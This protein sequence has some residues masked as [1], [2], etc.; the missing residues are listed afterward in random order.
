MEVITTPAYSPWSNGIVERHNQ[1]LTLTLNKIKQEENCNWGLALSWALSAKNALCNIHGF[2]AY[3]LVYGRNPNLPSN[4]T[5]NPPALEGITSSAIVGNHIRVLHSAKK[6]FTEAE[7]D[8][9]C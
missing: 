5:N 6:A 2:S 8:E 3:Q 7:C 4:L 1:T 9:S